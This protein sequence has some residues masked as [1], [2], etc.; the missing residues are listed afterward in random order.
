[1]Q[2]VFSGVAS[3]RWIGDNE[4]VRVLGEAMAGRCKSLPRSCQ[5][6]HKEAFCGAAEEHT[7]FVELRTR[8]VA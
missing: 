8:L 5:Y 7:L 4:A 2:I 6:R 1:V 3:G